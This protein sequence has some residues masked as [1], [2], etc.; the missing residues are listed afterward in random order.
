MKILLVH[1]NYSVK[2]G[3][4]V[5]VFEIARVL[6][7]NGHDVAFFTAWEE[8]IKVPN[9]DLFPSPADY[10]NGGLLRRLR[11]VPKAIYNRD[12]K[13]AF[14]SM[15]ERF[16]PDVVHAFAVYV[17]L[18][19]AIL[20]AARE[21]G[22]PVALSCNDYKHICPNYKLYHHGRICSDCKGGRF[23]NALY[24]RCAHNSVA[25]SAVSMAEAYV[26]EWRNLWRGNVDI[27]LFASRFMA[28]QTEAFWGKGTV[29]IDFLQNPFD[30]VKNHVP[31]HV[32][33]YI[34]YFGRLIEE[35][36]VDVILDAAKLCPNVPIVVVGD[37]PDWAMLE[38]RASDLD[39]VRFV[40]PAWDTD[41]R[42]WLE[43]A[44]AV[45]V[46]S[47]WH[48]NFPYVI[49]Q[50]FAAAL[51]VIASN[52]GG[53]PELVHPE[54]ERIAFGWTY[55]ASDP[56]ELAEIMREVMNRSE[57]DLEEMGRA[58]Q[59]WVGEQFSDNALYSRLINIYEGI[60]A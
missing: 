34:L 59:S 3:A 53:I 32:G 48:E 26:H 33:D 55:E 47:K 6:E 15:I 2:G 12:A 8:G 36:G 41:L 45:V 56:S 5:F 57:K 4:E 20:E 40:G 43:G 23:Y 21:A 60:K 1:N 27:F 28:S 50:A 16:K 39:N 52:R 42:A 31:A 9:S 30:A 25:I 19:P 13:A 22:I 37:G 54:A 18:T 24:N 10:K 35:K 38:D 17:R 49:L 46:P 51:P 11:Q 29:K 44:R 7:E 14:A 58:A